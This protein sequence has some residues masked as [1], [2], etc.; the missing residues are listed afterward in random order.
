MQKKRSYLTAKTNLAMVFIPRI[1]SNTKV[2]YTLWTKYKDFFI[3]THVTYDKGCG[4]KG[5]SQHKEHLSL[6]NSTKHSKD[7]HQPSLHHVYILCAQH[8][9]A[10]VSPQTLICTKKKKLFSEVK[11]K[12]R[13][14]W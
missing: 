5:Y 13:F 2:A 11:N 8:T 6:V 10:S 7:C 4:L 14:K 1:I 12:V 3:Q 9:K